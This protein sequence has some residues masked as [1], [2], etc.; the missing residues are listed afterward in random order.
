[1]RGAGPFSIYINT[2]APN[3][4]PSPCWPEMIKWGVHLGFDQRMAADCRQ[5]FFIKGVTNLLKAKERQYLTV[6]TR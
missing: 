2:C 5:V 1:M 3:E 4:P 6:R